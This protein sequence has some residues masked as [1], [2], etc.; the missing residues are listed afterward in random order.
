MTASIGIL[1]V[2]A[3]DFVLGSQDWDVMA[4]LT[5]PVCV[6]CAHTV[7]KLREDLLASVSVP[8]AVV[9][10]LST[11]PWIITNNTD[12]SIDR[13]ENIVI[14]EPPSCFLTHNRGI[15]I[16][17]AL[18]AEDHR[19]EAIDVLEREASRSPG[20]AQVLYNLATIHYGTGH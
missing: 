15:R 11:L 5:F 2:F 19:Q 14:D 16:A 1:S 6:L 18:L 9:C 10:L 17:L 3:F 7:S 13:L 12:A 20:N 8:T 4:L